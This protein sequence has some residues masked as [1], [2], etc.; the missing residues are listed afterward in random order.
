MSITRRQFLTL[1]GSVVGSIGLYHYLNN[2][3][4]EP[5]PIPGKV[6]CDLHAHPGN[7]NSLENILKMLGSPGLV[8]LAAWH[9]IHNIL[10]YEEARN[11]VKNDPSFEE[12]T[13]GQL[14]KYQEGYFACTQEIEVGIHHLLALGWKG[15]YFTIFK[16]AQEAIDA[17]KNKDGLVILNHPFVL[18][19]G[20]G[21]RTATV[22][23]QEQVQQLYPIVNEIEVHNAHAINLFPTL[24]MQKANLMA[25][26]TLPESMKGTAASDCHHITTQTKICG[27]YLDQTTIESQ[28]MNGIIQSI[29]NRNFTRLGNPHSGPYI[30]RMSWSK[31]ITLDRYYWKKTS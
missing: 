2:E 28:G 19:G 12:I 25:L 17:I 29:V 23:E 11:L 8:G 4:M 15:D 3:T 7:H 20:V 14:A 31:G 18:P 26:E 10:T 30:S 13:P 21:Y 9:N 6:L 27:I 16:N 24:M 1:G 22:K 5:T